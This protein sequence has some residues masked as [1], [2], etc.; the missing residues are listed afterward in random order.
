M[1]EKKIAEEVCDYKYGSLPS[2]APLAVALTPAQQGV[3]PRYSRSDALNRGT[4]FPGLD[5]PF[6]DM[7]NKSNPYAGTPL[8]DLM[9]VQ[10]MVQELKLYLDTHSDDKEAFQLLQETLKLQREAQTK[11]AEL[12]GPIT[13]SDMELS[14]SYT[15]IDSPWPWSFDANGGNK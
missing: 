5:L 3:E 4:L 14:K 8:G 2:C 13:F 9:A 12:Y 15:W 1:D 7:V 11:Y 6:M 10:F